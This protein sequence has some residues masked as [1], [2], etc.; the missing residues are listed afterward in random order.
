MMKERWGSRKEWSK[1]K[2]MN[3]WVEKRNMDQTGKNGLKRE[4]A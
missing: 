3:R 2:G 4:E 1:R